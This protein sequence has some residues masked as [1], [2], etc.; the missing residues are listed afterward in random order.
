MSLILSEMICTYLR[1]PAPP[2]AM[3]TFLFLALIKLAQVCFFEL[4]IAPPAR[5]V[6]I[7]VTCL[8]SLHKS[9]VEQ[10]TGPTSPKSQ[11]LTTGPSFLSYSSP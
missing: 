4:E 5:S 2:A 10:G 11:V 6:D 9:F 3:V 8:R 1:Q 7:Q